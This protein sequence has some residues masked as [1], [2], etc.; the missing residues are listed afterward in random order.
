MEAYRSRPERASRDSCY[1]RYWEQADPSGQAE[2]E[3]RRRLGQAQE[4]FGGEN[5]YRDER[6]AVWVRY[7]QPEV[8]LCYQAQPHAVDM[9]HSKI[10]I[11]QPWEIWEY[12]NLGRQFDFIRQGDYYRMV[13]S[14][15]SDALHPIAF[16]EPQPERQKTFFRAADCRQDTLGLRSARFRSFKPDL[17]RWEIYWWLPTAA[18][19]DQEYILIVDIEGPEGRAI[20]ETLGYRL[21]KPSQ[22]LPLPLAFG[23]SN[24]DLKP[25]FYRAD[26]QLLDVRER[27]CY[28]AQASAELLAYR[29]GVQESSDVELAVLSDTTYV[30]AQ[31]RKGDYRRIVAM[32]GETVEKYQ[33]FF[34][35][36]EIYN[37]SLSR[38]SCHYLSLQHQIFSTDDQGFSKECLIN[39]DPIE[40]T[41]P[42][43]TYRGCQKIHLL[44]ENL[45]PGRYVL[46]VNAEDKFTGRNSQAIVGFQIKPRSGPK[47]MSVK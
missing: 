12:K 21:V 7:G 20:A 4:L 11:E 30:S 37:L 5:F 3:H 16:F 42:G 18:L 10:L 39:T 46:R 23:Q 31:F 8:R 29:R 35:Y 43:T 45:P 41:Q 14:G 40:S 44:S 22:D 33:P 47:R 9:R 24:Y 34:V 19:K 32:P 17:M 27:V 13:W 26:L 36:Y 2:A 28:R 6:S 38:D 1:R 25:G 15:L